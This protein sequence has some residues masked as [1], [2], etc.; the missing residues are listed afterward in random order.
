MA[1]TQKKAGS[2]G[3]GFRPMLAYL[4]EALRQR[5]LTAK[6]IAAEFG[7]AEPTIRRWLHGRGLTLERLDQ[8]CTLAGIDLRDLAATLPESGATEFTLA[9]ERLLAADRARLPVLC[10]LERGR[11]G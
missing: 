2:A 4:R 1:S 6:T 8:L 10:N 7:V 9:Q 3:A 5:R 11:G